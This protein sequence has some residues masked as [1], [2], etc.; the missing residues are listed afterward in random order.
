MWLRCTPTTAAG[1]EYAAQGR[2]LITQVAGPQT[3]IIMMN[4]YAPSGSN[5][6]NARVQM[7]DMLRDEIAAHARMPC[8]VMGDF[9]QELSQSNL[10]AQLQCP[11]AWR[12]PTLVDENLQ[13]QTGTIQHESMAWLDGMILSPKSWWMP[14]IRLR[15]LAYLDDML[16]SGH[17]ST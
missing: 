6:V 12:L 15:S 1:R 10:H 4:V 9:N 2:L 11:Q 14:R 8:V 17:P 16:L 3:H 7:E 13:P 5:H